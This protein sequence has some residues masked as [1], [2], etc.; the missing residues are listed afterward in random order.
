MLVL[1]KNCVFP[2]RTLKPITYKVKPKSRNSLK[3]TSGFSISYLLRKSPESSSTKNREFL[4]KLEYQLNL[5]I[6]Q[7]V[8]PDLGFHVFKYTPT[9]TNSLS[10]VLWRADLSLKLPAPNYFESTLIEFIIL[11]STTPISREQAIL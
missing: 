8:W 3:S 4:I 11:F 2:A 6:K 7:R 1:T 9:Q 5:L 10:T